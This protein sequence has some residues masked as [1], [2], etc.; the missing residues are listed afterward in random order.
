M[1][2]TFFPGLTNPP[3]NPFEPLEVPYPVQP[4]F[5][6]VYKVNWTAPVF[7]GGL[8]SLRYNVTIITFY[9]NY[10]QSTD[11]H[12]LVVHIEPEERVTIYVEAINP[13]IDFSNWL[14]HP[15]SY[16]RFER[17]MSACRGKGMC[18]N[19]P[20]FLLKIRHF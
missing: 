15:Y 4:A 8:S 17:L 10:T 7:T 11:T 16:S 20:H 5:Y 14:S 12:S 3:G 13:A 19:I 2:S 1:I 18:M 6:A 9:D